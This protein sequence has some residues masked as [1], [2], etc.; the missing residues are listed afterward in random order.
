[1]LALGL[2]AQKDTTL[3]ETVEIKAFR[4]ESLDGYRSQRWQSDS[5]ELLGW[6]NLG[7]SLR[8]HSALFVRG[9][10]GNGIATLAARGTNASH[11]RVYWNGLDLGSPS[12]ALV[13][14]SSLPLMAADE[15]ELQYGGG[16]A[17]G[18][19]A[20]G[21]SLQLRSGRVQREGWSGGLSAEWGSF[22]HRQGRGNLQWKKG[23]WQS[24]LRLLALSQ[25]NDFPFPDVTETGQPYRRLQNAERI[26]SA[27]V[28]N[29]RYRLSAR[30]ELSL[31]LWA[32][33]LER[34]LPPPL[35]GDPELFDRM[36]DRSI[37]GIARYQRQDQHGQW[38][39]NSG[40]VLNENRFDLGAGDSSA[41]RHRFASW[42]N[43]LRWKS[44]AA[45]A[46]RRWQAEGG[47][48][49]HRVEAFSAAY[50]QSQRQDRYSLYGK[51]DWHWHERWST[52]LLLR[53]EYAGDRAAPLLGNWGLHW[54]FLPQQQLSLNLGRNWRMPSLNELY[55]QPGGNPNLRAESSE[56]I[57][58]SYQG[59]FRRWQLDWRSF[60]NRVDHWIQWLPQ[61]NFWAPENLKEVH[62]YGS[63]LSLQGGW[64]WRAWHLSAQ[65]QYAYLRSINAAA[66]R[67]ELALEGKS[68]PYVPEHSLSTGLALRRG[69][70][71]LRYSQNAYG[72]YF[73]SSEAR[74][75]LP[76]YSVA[77]LTLAYQVE[78]WGLSLN[79]RNL[80]DYPYQVIAYRPEPGFNGL[81]QIQYRWP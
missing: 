20:L 57:E 73:I 43:N 12:L 19:G 76:P 25:K 21:A 7:E 63:E 33:Q 28:S 51:W 58:F 49:L 70:W 4:S 61:G 13:D 60:F 53:S 6:Q 65:A 2:S 47:L 45:D 18:S 32:N 16:L 40:W 38:L 56:N 3:L 80:Y 55:W 52:S 37:N 15:L 81:L 66:Y 5:L 46:Q 75:Y 50:A 68:L 78:S 10:S 26:Q 14:L 67:P 74:S 31:Q 39:V 62:N 72:A 29:S 1:M 27:V 30:E 35:T 59:Q 71:Q 42:Q 23:R 8:E 64:Q 48:A 24:S 69:A 77:Q 41:S 11:S 36:W 44:K 79:L 17:E 9:H 34:S 22:G 54:R